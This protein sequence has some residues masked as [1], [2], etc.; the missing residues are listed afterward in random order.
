MN[1][2]LRVA[3]LGSCTTRDNFN[4]RFNPD[5]RSM[6]DCVL[7][8]NQSSI[9]SIMSDGFELEAERFGDIGE[10][11]RRLV[12]TDLNKEFLQQ[13]AEVRPDYLVM[14]FFSDIHFGC[15]KLG[16]GRYITNN[17]W[18]LWKTDYYKELRGRGPLDELRIEDDPGKYLQIWRDA[19][20][21]LMQHL[22]SR[23]PDTKVVLHRGFNTNRV[24]LSEEGRVLPLREF[25]K[26][27][28]L[29]VAVMNKLWSELDDYAAG[30]WG[31]EAIDLTGRGYTSFD[32][33]PWGA[34]F[35]HYT[36]D[37]YRD[38]LAELNLIHLRRVLG[39]GTPPGPGP[40]PLMLEQLSS[41]LR[42]DGEE[43]AAGAARQVEQLRSRAERLEAELSGV[44]TESPLRAMARAA[45][46]GRTR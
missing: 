4:S 35:V 12:R 36:M 7:S 44:L 23:V 11:K 3:V 46:R 43:R 45:R 25:K 19:F 28:K 34:F 18:Q 2:P 1:E 41:S 29:D 14:D 27:R 17:R 8:Q 31:L 6:W 21:R 15:L 5:Y 24:L 42:A 16:D 26:L 38:F 9:I 32:Q 39:S 20:D 40:L 13:L 10:Y 30:T 33:H 22:A 37:Y